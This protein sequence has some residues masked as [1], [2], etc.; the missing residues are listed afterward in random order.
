MLSI[1]TVETIQMNSFV[2]EED[3]ILVCGICLRIRNSEGTELCCLS[4][5]ADL[6]KLINDSD[7]LVTF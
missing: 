4:T 5:M 6:Y 2:N 3:I 1:L 7:K